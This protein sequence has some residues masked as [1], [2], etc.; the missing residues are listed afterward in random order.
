MRYERRWGGE[1]DEQ[2]GLHLPLPPPWTIH[3][4]ELLINLYG[5]FTYIKFPHVL[6]FD[7]RIFHLKKKV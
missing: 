4:E 3:I 7:E 2:V 1:V 6:S 5:L